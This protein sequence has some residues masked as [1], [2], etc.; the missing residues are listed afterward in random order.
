MHRRKSAKRPARY[1]FPVLQ[2]YIGN[3]IRDIVRA[4]CATR[5][6]RLSQSNIIY[7]INQSESNETGRVNEGM[8]S[9]LVKSG[10][11]PD[12]HVAKFIKYF[13]RKF[14]PGFEEEIKEERDRILRAE[15]TPSPQDSR[16]RE[17]MARE[18][19]REEWLVYEV[20]FLWHGQLPPPAETHWNFLTPEINQTKHL[21]HRAIDE[22]RLAAKKEIRS[23]TGIAR[24]V[25]LDQLRQFA[26]LIGERPRFLF[27]WPDK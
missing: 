12:I 3:R 25:T 5:G 7:E 26:E 22:G 9:K 4:Y 20:A 18:R 16:L 17:Y 10:D 8:F 2:K 27:D 24:T 11:V 19:G 15:E 13:D 21:I 1:Y 14:S 6:E 23:P